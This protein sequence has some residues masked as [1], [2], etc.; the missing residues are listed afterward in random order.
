MAQATDLFRDCTYTPLPFDRDVA[1]PSRQPLTASRQLDVAA[2]AA[3]ARVGIAP[4]VAV[5]CVWALILVRSSGHDDVTFR[6]AGGL[7]ARCWF[8]GDAGF[9]D[10]AR[11]FEA[12]KQQVTD[13]DFADLDLPVIESG[14]GCGTQPLCVRVEPRSAELQVV[15]DSARFEQ[16]ALELL[17]DQVEMGLRL[18]AANPQ[19]RCR[20]LVFTDAQARPAPFTRCAATGKSV[21]EL[22]REQVAQRP[23][24]AAVCGSSGLTYAELDARSDHLAQQLLA[25]GVQP[26]DHVALCLPR[27][28][29]LIVS[30]L[31]ILKAGAAYLP[32]EPSYPAARIHFMLDDASPRVLVTQS[33]LSARLPA[34]L[35][36]VR[37][38]L[39]RLAPLAAV[40]E[41]PRVSSEQLAYVLYTSGSTGKPKGVRVPHRAIER[42]VKHAT[43]ARL[44]ASVTMLQAAP[45]GFDASTLEVWGAL[46]NGGR[47]V[48]HSE[49]VP[50]AKGLARTVAEHGVTTMWLTAALFN[51]VVDDYATALSGLSQLLIGGET[52][53]V[54]HVRRA[55]AALP[56]T[57]IINGYGPTETTTFATC[58]TI[59]RPLPAALASIPIG[60]AI[61]D[62]QVFVR[63][64]AGRTLPRGWVGELHIGG[65]GVAL[66]YLGR[67]ELSAERFEGAPG[68]LVYRT[69]DWVRQRVDGV[70]EYVGR[71]DQQ[72]KIRGF[73]VELG[74]VEH[75]L[76]QLAS[77][78]SA[79]VIARSRP[80]GEKQ[81]IGYVVPAAPQR[82]SSDLRRELASVLPDYMI[83]AAI[84]WLDALPKTLN[85]KLDQRALPEPG[86]ARPEL[87]VEFV[88]PR[89]AAEQQLAQLWA[90]ALELDVIGVLDNLFELGAS[91]LLVVRTLAQLERQHGVVIPVLRVFETPTIAA[92][93]APP[94]PQAARAPARARN[95]GEGIAII[96]MAGRFPGAGS[97]AQLWQNL[98]A[99]K[100]SIRFFEESELDPSVAASLRRDPTYVSARGVLE[101]VELFD[102][103]FFG[104]TPKEAQLMDPQQRVLL[105]VAWE[106][107]EDAGC[108]ATRYPGTIGVFAGKYNNTY[109]SQN[110]Q[111]HPELIA[112]LGEFQTMVAN[113]KDY[114]ATRIA[115][116]LGLR[117]PAISVHTACSTSLVAVVQAVQNLLLGQCDVALAGGV[118]ITVPVHSG[119]LYQ[120]GAM[121]SQDGHTRSFDAR[122]SGTVFSDGAAMVV[123]KRLDDALADG[124]QIYGVIRGAATNNDG[125]NKASFTAP[126]SAGQA[127][128]ISLALRQAA[129]SARDILYV[130]AHGTAT[131]LGDPIEVEAL[132]RAFRADTPDRGFC[133]LG[134]V[135]SNLGHLV[136]AAGVT[137]LIKTA[138]S[139]RSR[140]LVPSLH[141]A[142]PNPKID[143]EASPFVV[144]TSL[145][146]WPEPAQGK[147]RLAAVSSF[148]VGGTNAHVIV[149][150][151]PMAAEDS[152]A[153]AVQLLCLSACSEP[154]LARAAEALASWLEQNPQLR[155]A[156]VAYTLKAGRAEHAY[157]CYATAASVEQ[158]CSALRAA[159]TVKVSGRRLR[160][161]LMFPGQGAQCPGMASSL[162]RDYAV[163]REHVDRA[164]ALLEPEL[165]RDLRELLFL[166]TA[167]AEL[168]QTSFTQPA[169]FTVG[170]ALAQLWRSFGV[171]PAAMLGHSVGEFVC[172]ALAGVMRFEDALSLVAA[173]GRM[174]QAL[175]SGAMLSVRLPASQV[176]PLLGA[177]CAV[178][179]DNAPSLCVA[180]GPH[181]EIERLQRSLEAQGVVC[182]V[183]QTSHAFHSPMMEPAVSPLGARLA[184]VP[185]SA[186]SIPIVSTVSGQ[187]LT[188]QQARDPS[189]WAEQV[190]R[191]VLFS[192]AVQQLLAADDLILLEAG[193]RT[194]LATLARQHVRDGSRRRCISS[195][196]DGDSERDAHA[197]LSAAGQLWALGVPVELG[198]TGRKVSLPTY[199]FER[200]RYWV[201]RHAA[202]PNTSHQPGTEVTSVSSHRAQLITSLQA[203][204]EETSGIELTEADMQVSF[205]E[206]GLDSL[207]LTQFALALG[208]KLGLQISFRQLLE[209]LPS[210]AVLAEHVERQLPA[211]TPALPPQPSAAAPASASPAQ[212][213]GFVQALIEQQ[214]AIM[215]QQL[216]LLAGAPPPTAAPAEPVVSVAAEEPVENTARYDVKKAFGAI[217][218]ITVT[219]IEG[220]TP[221]QKAK[222]DALTR[223]YNEKTQGSKRFTQEHRRVVADPRVVTG[224]RPLTKELVYPLVVDRSHGSKLWDIDG[225]EYV[226]ALN[227][228][229]LSLFGW[230]PELVTQAVEQQLRRGHEIGPQHPLQAEVAKLVCELTGME[231]AAFCNTGSEA[232]MGCA[233]I[234]RTVTGRNKIAIFSGSYHG[235][236]DEVVVRGTKKLRSIPAAPGIMPSTAENVLVLDYGTDESLAIL[237]QRAEE[238]AAIIVEP[239]QSRRPDF[240][241]REFLHALR[242][243]TAKHGVVLVFDEVVTGFRTGPGGAQQFFDVKADLAAYGKVIGGGLPIGVIA[244]ER[245]FMDAL[246]GGYWAFGDDSLPEVGVTYFAGTFVRHP[247]ALAAAKAV[248]THLKESGPGLQQALNEKTAQFAQELNLFFEQVG[249]PIRIKYFASLWKAFFT[250]D[251]PF[252]DLLFFMM[253]DRGV[254]I[255]DGFPCFFTTAH[256]AA[257]TAHIAKAFKDSV[258]EMQDG[259]FLPERKP[260]PKAAALDASAPPAP[261]ARL[262]RDPSGN[263]AWFVP[264]PTEPHK[265][266]K[267]EVN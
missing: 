107:L 166:D 32:I 125:Q 63:D 218:R 48:L 4:E 144:N 220:L 105:E 212:P 102:A 208:K 21:P 158:A 247:L 186:P 6:T 231:R 215:Q 261:G 253:R 173:R 256:S 38:E 240:Q 120:E 179:S 266:V 196:S 217:A 113:E 41:W 60:S 37:L 133:A 205:V 75:A 26:E 28:P 53:S 165:G 101:G 11:R 2:F 206:L 193:P 106:A 22:F 265:Y 140:L 13:A 80:S 149:E 234:A 25:L 91:S 129:V 55:L 131:P 61:R 152:G 134:S 16:A 65:R 94:P 69:G 64:A 262:G 51:A 47:L 145:R 197:L 201:D 174:L 254:H 99:G 44:D 153:R 228:F 180:S 90:E 96:G 178:A 161:A 78:R 148:G 104:I 100:E 118:S 49:L 181:A 93:A 198:C 86:R 157:R 258:L 95:L 189:Y 67:P 139:L 5:E 191:P 183:L 226:D 121:L 56:S 142:Q 128:V 97:V 17:A 155:L 257:D 222:L 190:R 188:E 242:P 92:L 14:V 184:H 232:V 62:T 111:A 7:P 229:G 89:S 71:A 249:A 68:E 235:I 135:K 136:T 33:S 1:A 24:S 176:A 36:C 66:G 225:H 238:L 171:E 35:P 233:R 260:A 252:A 246:D 243:L 187:W 73:R 163:F 23:D 98:C 88:A 230:Q 58:Y 150:Q 209:E 76:M 214:L 154:A 138:L 82:T 264:H 267:H 195:L 167:A 74:E 143:F 31:A 236:F 109:F 224:F 126:S 170:Y 122:A 168:S 216:A 248:L 114:I 18:I 52:L 151:P 124:D 204:L 244:G 200:K 85:G 263:P 45:L 237:E 199:P 43:F 210:L 132:T 119:H 81:L 9:A 156:D 12:T 130:E 211:V 227:G 141:F 219:K 54:P 203:L 127:A 59:E 250:T 72:V 213:A 169:L 259:G 185:L 27:G 20:D 194:T 137:G 116:R 162:Y 110:V 159:T 115:H 34:V 160:V 70:L 46:L 57:E 251:Q 77:V 10:W 19:A 87:A 79:A 83:P 123:L 202:G 245:R 30:V 112:E 223:R 164:A 207:F 40:Y 29:E 221:R 39:D 172:A 3:L 182:R 175:P 103:A 42:L 50:T 255:Y 192:Q 241:P 177:A 84:V 8:D 147:Q 117:G 146:S 15:G 239:V 108:D